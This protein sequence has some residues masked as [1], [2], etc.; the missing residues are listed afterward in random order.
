MTANISVRV[1]PGY[2]ISVQRVAEALGVSIAHL[3]RKG[4][5]SYAA[6]LENAPA[7]LVE[8]LLIEGAKIRSYSRR[9]AAAADAQNGLVVAGR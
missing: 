8:N 5:E 2:A 9:P 6:Q 1:P 4:V 7:D 3:V